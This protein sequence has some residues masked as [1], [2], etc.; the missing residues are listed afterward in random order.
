MRKFGPRATITLGCLALL[1][2]TCFAQ[3][4]YPMITHTVPVA[5]QRGKITDITVEGQMDFTGIYKTLFD[6]PA[7]R[8]E[9]TEIPPPAPRPARAGKTGRGRKQTPRSVKIK[10]TVPGTPRL[11]VHDFRL[12]SKLGISSVGQLVIVDDPVVEVSGDNNII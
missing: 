4:S 9:V 12:V 10:L 8:A 11:D 7:L 6:D 5:V 3:T 2:T 1:P